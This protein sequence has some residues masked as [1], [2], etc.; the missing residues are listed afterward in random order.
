MKSFAKMAR[1]LA[2]SLILCLCAP[3]FAQ[4]YHARL[5]SEA[6]DEAFNLGRR[7]DQH[8]AAFLGQYFR[9]FPMPPKGPYISS[10]ELLTP[11]AQVATHAMLNLVNEN[12]FNVEK[13]Y[14]TRVGFVQL[15]VRVSSTLS[16][17]LPS[18]DDAVWKEFVITASQEHSLDIKRK[19]L[20]RVYPG[21]DGGGFEYTDMVLR[22]SAE[23]VASSP[24][25]IEVSTSGGQQVEAKFDLSKLE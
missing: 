4:E 6:I 22:L 17:S 15:T 9:R 2:C 13:K 19:R 11:Y 8:T 1:Y 16:Y 3:L 7:N 12:I 24:I 23:E 25:T 10:I 5:S 14:G 18:D 20:T 21:D